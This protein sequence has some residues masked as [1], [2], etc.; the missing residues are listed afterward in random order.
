MNASSIDG[1]RLAEVVRNA[2]VPL[3]AKGVARAALG[4]SGRKAVGEVE[5]IL[6]SLQQSGQ[7]HKYPPRQEGGV[8]RFSSVPPVEWVR[9]R[10][11]GKVKDGGGRVTQNQVRDHLHKWERSLYDDAVGGLI[12]DGKLHY[13]TV[14][15]KRLVS[16]SPTPFDYLLERQVTALK[17]ILERINRRRAKPLSLGELKSFLDG[18]ST[19]AGESGELTEEMLRAW[20]DEDV[21]R[22]GGVTS[23]PIPWTWEHYESW[24]KEHDFRADVNRFHGLLRSLFQAGK[25]ELIPHSRTHE[26]PLR[27][28]ELALSGQGGELLYYWRWH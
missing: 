26:T 11:L 3:T 6:E 21:P 17:E 12:R 5:Q 10:I 23:V 25:I 19:A 15:H 4:S 7:L 20:Y 24:C 18:S 13:L 16:F 22:L 27:E 1:N 28:A 14:R 8:V 2:G 9:G